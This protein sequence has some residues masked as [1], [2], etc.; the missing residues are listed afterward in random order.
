MRQEETE[1]LPRGIGSLRVGIG[2]D[3]TAPCP[4]MPC[5][6]DHPLLE[7][8]LTS[9]IGVDDATVTTPVRDVTL[10]RRR[11]CLQTVGSDAASLGD[12]LV[13]IAR[14][15][16]AVLIAM[17]HDRRHHPP[18]AR[19]QRCCPVRDTGGGRW[20]QLEEGRSPIVG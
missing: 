20:G 8:G 4:G 3:G 14:I 17:K 16:S 7:H 2:A 12:N 6:V 1:H 15:D 9:S 19:R 13:A 11:R 10:L 5:T 18:F